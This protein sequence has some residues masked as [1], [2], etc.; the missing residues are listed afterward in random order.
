VLCGAQKRQ[1]IG[2]CRRPAGWGTSH[3]GFGPCKLHAGS[4]PTVSRGAHRKAIE[5]EA[6]LMLDRL[7]KPKPLGH[8][9]EELLAIGA[10][11]RAWLGITRERLAELSSLT[12]V[13]GSGV[14]RERA[15]VTV[16]ERAL[17]RAARVLTELARLG[18]EERLIR[19]EEVRARQLLAAVVDALDRAAVPVHYRES[20][21]RELAAGL[22]ALVT[23]DVIT[24]EIDHQEDVA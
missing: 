9:V 17:D 22:R 24:V 12:S 16:Y 3:A 15:L 10:E 2:N 4:T 11:V 21:R 20:F 7:G 23:G 13:D 1:G 19:V 5:A 6:R 18:L 14:E 8:P